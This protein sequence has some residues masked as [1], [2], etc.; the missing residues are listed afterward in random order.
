ME[1]YDFSVYGYFAT[2]IEGHCF[3]AQDE[4]SLLLAAG[5]RE[6]YKMPLAGPTTAVVNAA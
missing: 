3:P 4:V 2:T 1:W 5:L 6:T